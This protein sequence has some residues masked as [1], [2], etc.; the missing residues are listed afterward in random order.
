MPNRDDLR[1][2]RKPG[3]APVGL[4]EALADPAFPL[5]AKI[6]AQHPQVLRFEAR[7]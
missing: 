1:V 2:I 4:Q 5:D 6:D 7:H 3:A